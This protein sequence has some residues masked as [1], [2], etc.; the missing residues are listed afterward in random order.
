M[1]SDKV[2]RLLEDDLSPDVAAA[3]SNI[4][5]YMSS[6]D[7]TAPVNDDK[8]TLGKIISSSFT[9]GYMVFCAEEQ[10]RKKARKIDQFSRA[11][12]NG[13]G[14][15]T[16]RIPIHPPNLDSL[17][18]NTAIQVGRG[19]R[20]KHLKIIRDYIVG[21]KSKKEIGETYGMSPFAIQYILTLPGAMEMI[22]R[23]QETVVDDVNQI[24]RKA[25]DNAR[26]FLDSPKEDVKLDMTKFILSHATAIPKSEVLHR[27]TGAD[28]VSPVEVVTT[29]RMAKNKLLTRAGIDPDKIIDGE[30]VEIK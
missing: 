22:A 29:E 30:F 4:D 23:F 17:I 13:R 18:R 11:K 15:P 12:R 21:N 8:K 7:K 5:E 28:G 19:L 1:Q 16:N 2:N 10:E 3:T 25:L 27:V 6:M 20:L 24:N 14:R 26:T 9:K